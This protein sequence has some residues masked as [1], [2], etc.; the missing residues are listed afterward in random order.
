MLHRDRPEQ[1]KKIDFGDNFG[2]LLDFGNYPQ[3][4]PFYFARSE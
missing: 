2:N 3:S 1:N 4:L